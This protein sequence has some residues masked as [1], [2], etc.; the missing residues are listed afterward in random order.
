MDNIFYIQYYVSLFGVCVWGACYA[1]PAVVEKIYSRAASLKIYENLGF[2]FLVLAGP[3]FLM[4]LKSLMKPMFCVEDPDYFPYPVVL[5]DKKVQCWGS[6]HLSLIWPGLIGLCIFFPSA[7]LTTA[8]K[9]SPQEDVRFLFLYTRFEFIVKGLM[10]FF[11]LRFTNQPAVAMLMLM[12]GSATIIFILH[13]M[14]PCCLY[15]AN[16]W[17]HFTHVCNIWTCLTCQWA[18]VVDNTDWKSHLAM[19]AAGWITL[20]TVHA[21]YEYRKA[22]ADC[23][24]IAIDDPTLRERCSAEILQLRHDIAYAKRWNLWGVHASI[25]RLLRYAKHEDVIVR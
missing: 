24:N 14:K 20:F 15:W 21:V 25:L 11:S 13:F 17:K 3:G 19:A 10:L 12:L 1:L 22:Q 7:T 4:I 8:I 18:I 16:R 2:I 23:F 5:A 6:T 9:Y